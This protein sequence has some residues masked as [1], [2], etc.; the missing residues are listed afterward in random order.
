[1]PSQNHVTTHTNTLHGGNNIMTSDIC[2]ECLNFPGPWPHTIL[3]ISVIHTLISLT[4]FVFP[5]IILAI[6]SPNLAKHHNHF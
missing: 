2:A 3:T 1:M 5:I 6:R 4:F